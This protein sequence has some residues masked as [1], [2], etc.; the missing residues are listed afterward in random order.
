MPNSK[1][2]KEKAERNQAFLSSISVAAY[3]EW[4]AVVAFYTAVHL[5]ERLRTLPLTPPPHHSTDRQ[6]RL[7]F[8]QRNH[9]SIHNSFR[10]L[11]DASILARYQPV[12]SFGKQF[13]V[14]DVEDI[15]IGQYLKEIEDYVNSQF[16]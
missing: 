3:P 6:H 11:F 7:S 10:T 9:R 14:Q 8:V 15:L 12:S 5:V 13:S 2:H 4:A 1:Q 16:P